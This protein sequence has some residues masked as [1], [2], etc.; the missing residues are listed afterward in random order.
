VGIEMADHRWYVLRVR[1]HFERVTAGHLEARGFQPFVPWYR[2]KRTW[3]DRVKEIEL[4][5][6]P[7]YVFCQL[8]L[9]NRFPILS[10]PG[11]VRI[12]SASNIPVPVDPAEIA[13][14]QGVAGSGLPAQPWPFL[15]AGQTVRVERGCLRGI[16]GTLLE[17]SKKEHLVVSV[18]LLQRSVAVEI[19]RDWVHPINS[20]SSLR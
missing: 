16:E 15:R 12:V 19:D 18:T 8:V 1:A 3:S 17:V 2:S 9:T 7:G 4:P 11:V 6:F 20:Q 10:A 13:A 14:V 5:L